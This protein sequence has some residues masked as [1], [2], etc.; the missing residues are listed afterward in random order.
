[1]KVV[2]FRTCVYNVELLK[3]FWFERC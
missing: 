2:V 3:G 1:M